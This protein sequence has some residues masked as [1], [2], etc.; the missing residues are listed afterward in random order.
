[1][2]EATLPIRTTRVR[3]QVNLLLGVKVA[4]EEANWKMFLQ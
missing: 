4:S 2:R 3:S 1:M